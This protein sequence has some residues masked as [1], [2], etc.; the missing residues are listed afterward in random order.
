ME[1]KQASN[2]INEAI[3]RILMDIIVRGH[4]HRLIGRWSREPELQQFLNQVPYLLDR[5]NQLHLACTRREILEDEHFHHHHHHHHYHYHQHHR[6]KHQL[7]AGKTS[8][9]DFVNLIGADMHW[10]VRTRDPVG[11][12]PLHK[13]VLHNNR[14]IAEYILDRYPDELAASSCRAR[15][16]LKANDQQC[17]STVRLI[18]SQDKYGRTALHYAA[19][20][21]T[22]ARRDQSEWAKG[23]Q[24]YFF[25]I[26]KGASQW[27]KDFQGKTA[28]DYVRHPHQLRSKSIIHL[29]NKLSANYQANI[30][31]KTLR[32]TGSQMAMKESVSRE[33]EGLELPIESKG[34][35]S[36][37][38]GDLR[39]LGKQVKIEEGGER[40]TESGVKRSRSTMVDE[41]DELVG[42]RVCTFGEEQVNIEGQRCGSGQVENKAGTSEDLRERQL[43]PD[44]PLTLCSEL[45]EVESSDTESAY[46]KLLAERC[47]RLIIDQQTKLDIKRRLNEG[48]VDDV[49]EMLA[50][51]YGD[52]LLKIAPV[53]CWNRQCK[54]YISQVIPRLLVQLDKLHELIATNQL[55]PIRGLL[56][57]EPILARLRRPYKRS[58]MAALHLAVHF[59]RRGIIKYLVDKFPELIHQQDSHGATCLHWA[60]KSL[61]HDRIFFWLSELFGAQLEHVRDFRGK[62]AAD[63]RQQAIKLSSFEVDHPTRTTK[64]VDLKSI[65]RE[66][67]VASNQLQFS[68][69]KINM[70]RRTPPELGKTKSITR[71]ASRT[72]GRASEL[73][74][75][76][77]EAIGSIEI[78]IDSPSS[79]ADTQITSK[80][81][82]DPERLTN[83]SQLFERQMLNEIELVESVSKSPAY[84][85]RRFSDSMPSTRKIP[86]DIVSHLSDDYRRYK[87]PGPVDA[88][89]DPSVPSEATAK[90]DSETVDRRELLDELAQLDSEDLKS[91]DNRGLERNQSSNENSEDSPLD[92]PTLPLSRPNSAFASQKL[93]SIITNC[94]QTG[95]LKKLEHLILA[96]CGQ[97]LL[98]YYA[99]LKLNSPESCETISPKVREFIESCAPE[100][101]EKVVQ[102]HRILH[103]CFAFSDDKR[104]DVNANFHKLCN[105]LDRKRMIMSRDSYGASPLHVAIMRSDRRV[106]EYLIRRHPEAASAPDNGGR[107]AFHYAA[108]TLHTYINHGK[109]RLTSVVDESQPVG[110]WV[111]D[112][113]SRVIYENLC[114]R[115]NDLLQLKDRKGNSC[116]QYLEPSPTTHIPL[117]DQGEKLINPVVLDSCCRNYASLLAKYNYLIVNDSFQ[118]VP[119]ISPVSTPVLNENDTAPHS[120][121]DVDRKVMGRSD[122]CENSIQRSREAPNSC[123]RTTKALISQLDEDKL[124][125][126]PQTPPNTVFVKQVAPK[127]TVGCH[128]GFPPI[129][130]SPTILAANKQIDKMGA[131]LVKRKQQFDNSTGAPDGTNSTG[132]SR[133]RAHNLF[134]EFD[135]GQ[136]V[137]VHAHQTHHHAGRNLSA[138]QSIVGG[139]IVPTI[140][141]NDKMDEIETYDII[142]RQ[143]PPPPPPPQLSPAID[144]SS[145]EEGEHAS[146]S[147]LSSTSNDASGDE[148]DDRVDR[149][150]DE[151]ESRVRRE[152]SELKAK[153]DQIMQQIKTSAKSSKSSRFLASPAPGMGPHEDN[154]RGGSSTV[155][156]AMGQHQ[157]GARSPTT[158]KTPSSSGNSSAR[159]SSSSA[160]SLS[161]RACSSSGSRS[162]RSPNLRASSASSTTSSRS[163]SSSSASSSGSSSSSQ[164]AISVSSLS[165]VKD[166]APKQT[167]A[168]QI[169][170]SEI[171]LAKDRQIDQKS[172]GQNAHDL[173]AKVVSKNAYGQTYLH[174]IASRAQS[175]STLYKVLDHGKHLIG[176]RDI[177]YRTARDVALQFNLPNNV[178]VLDKFII[179]LFIEANTSLLRH[180]LNQ[181]YSPLIHVSDSDG[182][183]IM[184]ILKLLKL[185][186]M[187]QFLLQMA[188]F[189]R[190]RDELHTFIRHGYSAGV[191]ELIRKHKDLVRAK[192]IHSRTSLHLAILFDRLDMVKELLETDPT[193]VHATDNMGR[194]ALHYIYGLN[195]KNMQPIRDLLLAYGSSLDTRDVK[196]RTPKYYYIFKREIEDIKRVELELD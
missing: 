36:V 71:T 30:L 117:L 75:I 133:N 93:D 166:N 162:T 77:S 174:F 87:G 18:D 65:L 53:S 74:T 96:G 125:V 183:D 22:R 2:Q 137:R 9:H 28:L 80:P 67:Q 85:G 123:S 171:T 106:V 10:L 186:R 16:Q 190:W 149:L 8:L 97:R 40:S 181:G 3:R 167:I 184:L 146:R 192:S 63:Y 61:R 173:T 89:T 124:I 50:N 82:S 127:P 158:A 128:G 151:F 150:S 7:T 24:L 21:L 32:A 11:L 196:M 27:I 104:I 131:K 69:S 187:I 35:M 112:E 175:V 68:G 44:S 140:I 194:T 147:D 83:E 118:T 56:N 60:A 98:N 116:S 70:K 155:M 84:G 105:L 45:S 17:P 90:L 59:E 164:S 12:T 126:A 94:I 73:E 38:C 46:K 48:T 79:R 5:I 145:D 37:S 119:E 62:S 6:S 54:R 122:S 178:K 161:G 13:A 189:Q 101:I 41:T 26:Q 165:G 88:K 143:P 19:A 163:S 154:G 120:T 115:Y 92:T 180:L 100:Y 15:H 134:D 33:T 144:S 172:D 148:D 185:D 42:I 160:S 195:L 23:G 153:V 121:I 52:Y 138:R 152:K 102:V 110:Y 58:A 136:R 169:G 49:V 47:Q 66:N 157:T 188:D 135:S 95:D 142:Y 159:T 1:H 168:Q 182:N 130:H 34:S 139:V 25:L 170:I 129:S 107:N 113:S 78:G 108:I 191:S 20:L 64:T 72:S 156:L 193:S 57:K 81:S 76:T 51:G 39:A 91:N 141:H 177:F 86:L 31:S 99:N 43:T 132:H 179:D 14:P 55:E 111:I 114:S 29:A 176:E 103:R 109:F 4:G